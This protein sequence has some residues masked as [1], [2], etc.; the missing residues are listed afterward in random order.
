MDPGI[1]PVSLTSP[2]LQADSLPLAPPGKSMYMIL[3]KPLEVVKDRKVWCAAVYGVAELD[4]KLRT[5]QQSF[6]SIILSILHIL[7]HINLTT[8]PHEITTIIVQ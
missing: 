7:S 5:E 8:V 3:G 4:M 1:E 6:P 2:V